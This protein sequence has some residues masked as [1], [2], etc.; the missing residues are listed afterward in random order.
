[1]FRENEASRSS[2]L[3]WPQDI[4]HN[5]TGRPYLAEEMSIPVTCGKWPMPSRAVLIEMPCFWGAGNVSAGTLMLLDSKVRIIFKLQQANCFY[6][7]TYSKSTEVKLPSSEG[8]RVASNYACL[9]VSPIGY[10]RCI[11]HSSRLTGCGN[12]PRPICY[13][14]YS[15]ESF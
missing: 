12:H 10:Q 13:R 2:N 5:C 1:V 9:C 14:L 15:I 3:N 4:A 11:I 7:T 6:C 8:S